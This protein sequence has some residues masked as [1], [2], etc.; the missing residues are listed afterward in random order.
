MSNYQMSRPAE[1]ALAADLRGLSHERL[2]V[3]CAALATSLARIA[4]ERVSRSAH[5]DRANVLIEHA[6]DALRNSGFEPVQSFA[7]SVRDAHREGG[8]VMSTLTRSEAMSLID[9]ALAGPDDSEDIRSLCL[10]WIG[11]DEFDGTLEETAE[12]LREY[13]DECCLTDAV[14][15]NGPRDDDDTGLP[16]VLAAGPL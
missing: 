11:H 8:A 2:A 9:E 7:P 16:A 15:S 3:L 12:V 4:D 10:A 5:E 1:S 6:D 13:V 14:R